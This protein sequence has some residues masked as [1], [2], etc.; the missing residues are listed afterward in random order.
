MLGEEQ[1][2]GMENKGGYEAASQKRVYRVDTLWFG[3]VADPSMD[4]QVK[5]RLISIASGQVLA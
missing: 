2:A 5:R 3:E 1:K 4:H